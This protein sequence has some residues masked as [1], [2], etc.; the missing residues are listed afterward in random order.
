MGSCAEMIRRP[1]ARAREVEAGELLLGIMR[2]GSCIYVRA[3]RAPGGRKREGCRGSGEVK[4]RWFVVVD[5]D[6]RVRT[7]LGMNT[8]DSGYRE[9]VCRRAGTCL[10]P[11]AG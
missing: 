8:F 5:K 6:G 1:R 10:M 3:D 7:T 9:S 2:S 11:T 4:A